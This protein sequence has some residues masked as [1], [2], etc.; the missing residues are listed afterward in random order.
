MLCDQGKH[1]VLVACSSETRAWVESHLSMKRRNFSFLLLNDDGSFVLAW[2]SKKTSCSGYWA[3]LCLLLPVLVH[4]L[5]CIKSDLLESLMYLASINGGHL[6]V[7][8][9]Q[10]WCALMYSGKHFMLCRSSWQSET[11]C[12]KLAKPVKFKQILKITPSMEAIAKPWCKAWRGLLGHVCTSDASLDDIITMPPVQIKRRHEAS[13]RHP[14]LHSLGPQLIVMSSLHHVLTGATGRLLG[15]VGAEVGVAVH[16]SHGLQGLQ[17]DLSPSSAMP[18]A[19][20]KV[21]VI[22]WRSPRSNFQKGWS[23]P[24]QICF[25]LCIW[26][27][28]QLVVTKSILIRIS[29]SA[30]SAAFTSAQTS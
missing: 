28:N 17:P 15:I 24:P 19:G 21:V 27:A 26:K 12:E 22:F 5:H 3:E 8:P 29:L 18:S 14:E 23:R 13:A 11:V 1:I 9:Q 20:V 6:M 30:S 10:Y 4:C 25:Q 16:P 7:S 2:T